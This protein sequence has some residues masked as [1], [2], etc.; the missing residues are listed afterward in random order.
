MLELVKFQ[1][2]PRCGQQHLQPNDAK[3]FVCRLCGFVYYHSSAAIAGAIIE[4]QDR[5][6]LTRRAFEPHKDALSLPGGFV[7][8]GE[9][10]E[11]ALVREIQEE[12]NIS[13][14]P[15][16]YFCSGGEQYKSRDVI[17]FCTT[18]FF[19]VKVYDISPIT[20]RDD[21]DTFLLIAPSD[22]DLEKLAFKADRVAIEK[23]R[24]FIASR[25][26]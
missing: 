10:L 17:Y 15:P 16:M 8:Y 9:S 19:I 11:D 12:L 13:V 20:A 24:S 6:I 18:A 5:I 21:V 22:I 25:Q 1:Y 14:T 4:Y 2:C 3:S 26:S 7:D 23:Y